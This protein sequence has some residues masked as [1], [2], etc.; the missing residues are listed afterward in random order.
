MLEAEG[1]VKRFGGLAAVDDVS[2][3]TAEGEILGVIGPNGAGKSTLFNLIT[4]TIPMTAGKVRFA[5]RDI[6][7]MKPEKVANLGVIRTFQSATVF[8]EKTVCE[9]VRIGYQ[10]NQ[11]G[12]PSNLFNRRRVRDFREKAGGVV[13]EVLDFVG[14][15]AF[16]DRAAGELS[17]GGQKVLGVAMALAAGP[18]QLLMDEP[19]AGLNAVETR[20]MGELIMAIRDKKGIDVV[21]VEHDMAMVTSICDR[22]LVINRGQVLA[23]GTPDEIQRNPD[24]IEAYLGVDLELD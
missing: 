22:I 18:K 17:Y 14:L 20:Q 1:L 7:G 12:C 3:S 4:G 9:N 24:V 8:R 16:K 15:T 11:L 5:G 19:A 6:T 21:L 10:F 2:F 23:L 13:A